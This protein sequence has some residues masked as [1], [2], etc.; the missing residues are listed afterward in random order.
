M[1]LGL[2]APKYSGRGDYR[3][4][5]FRGYVARASRI[6]ILDSIQAGISDSIHATIPLVCGTDLGNS[7]AFI[8]A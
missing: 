1:S 3:R 4:F 5:R 6:L 8:F 2:R 7:L